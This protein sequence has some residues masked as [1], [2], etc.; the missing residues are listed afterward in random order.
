MILDIDFFKEVNDN[1]GHFV[2]DKV[3]R[4]FGNFL[5]S[6]FREDDIVGRIG[7]DEFVIL[8]RNLT[9]QNAVERK[10]QKLLNR[11]S[12]LRIEEMN[13]QGITISVGIALAPQHGKSFMELIRMRI[14][15][16]IV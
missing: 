10:I 4:T 11:I 7:G 9:D 14:R 1:Y 6:Q 15:L 13:G 12:E 3:L 16:C 5:K 2:G 8:M